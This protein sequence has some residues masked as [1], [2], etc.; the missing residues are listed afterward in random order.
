MVSE[1]KSPLAQAR[2]ARGLS[3]AQLAQLLGLKSKSY[4]C[5][6]ERNNAPSLWVAIA[7]YRHL[8]VKTGP[9]ADLT[10]REINILEKTTKA[11]PN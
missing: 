6:I 8:D 7:L 11:R 1:K 9:I 3:Q 2:D 10:D 4:I 5:N